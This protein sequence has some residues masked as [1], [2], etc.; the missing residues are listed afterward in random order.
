MTPARLLVAATLGSVAVLTGPVF[1]GSPA[2][3][4]SPPPPVEIIDKGD[5]SS[6]D[7]GSKS[8]NNPSPPSLPA[9][10]ASATDA[11]WSNLYACLTVELT[12][13][14]TESAW[15]GHTAAEGHIVQDICPGVTPAQ[16]P[17]YFVPFDAAGPVVDPVTLAREAFNKI[18]FPTPVPH[19][20]PDTVLAVNRWLYLSVDDPGVLSATAAVP[21]LSVTATARLSSTRWSMGELTAPD[22]GVRVPAFTCRGAGTKP[23]A[24]ATVSVAE[25]HDPGCA[26]WYRLRSLPERTAGLGTWPVTVSTTWKVDWSATNGMAGTATR[27]QTSPPLNV[28]VGEW[29]T[30]AVFDDSQEGPR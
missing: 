22:S 5:G 30:V 11:S 21:T 10:G 6:F 28:S 26:Y 19:L 2:A 16:G 12:A 29:R 1:T 3:G 18:P 23:A 4:D 8:A 13:S 14:P 15:A 25:P 27:T 20:G 9:A 7:F 24:A 17:P